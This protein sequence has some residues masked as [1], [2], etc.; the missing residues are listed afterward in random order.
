MEK[1]PEVKPVK[2]KPLA[3]TKVETPVTP[4]ITWRQLLA[5]NKK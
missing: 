3:K 5:Q 2:N 1:T 4:K